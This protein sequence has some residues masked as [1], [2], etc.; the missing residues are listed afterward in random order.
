MHKIS[1]SSRSNE[2]G[3]HASTGLL[4]SIRVRTHSWQIVAHIGA[5]NPILSLSKAESSVEPRQVI[6]SPSGT[7]SPDGSA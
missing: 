4:D 2:I 5:G 1:G 3:N 7:F 6:T